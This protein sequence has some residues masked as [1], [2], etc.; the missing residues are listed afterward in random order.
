VSLVHVMFLCLCVFCVLIFYC[1]T[2][3]MI[4]YIC[5]KKKGKETAPHSTIAVYNCVTMFACMILEYCS[6]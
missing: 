2:V 1:F 5:Y 4:M 3:C 6:L